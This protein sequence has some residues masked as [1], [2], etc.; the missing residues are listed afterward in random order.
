MS[1]H[2]AQTEHEVAYQ[3][4]CGLLYRQAEKV[5]AEE[6]LAIAS[7]MVGKLIAM[8]D[9]RTMTTDRAMEIV[10]HNLEYGNRTIIESLAGQEIAGSA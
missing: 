5:S 3:E 7:N 1:K 4:L 6:L 10:M 2:A 8:Q 9:K